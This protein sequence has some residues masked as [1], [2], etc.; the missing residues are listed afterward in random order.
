MNHP[1]NEINCFL[2]NNLI[3]KEQIYIHIYIHIQDNLNST[4]TIVIFETIIDTKTVTLGQSWPFMSPTLWHLESYEIPSIFGIS[5]ES[6]NLENC[7]YFFLTLFGEQIQN[8][9]HISTANFSPLSEGV[10]RFVI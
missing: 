1:R 5:E 3:A 10:V 9:F 4:L 7:F 8:K 6:E 2:D